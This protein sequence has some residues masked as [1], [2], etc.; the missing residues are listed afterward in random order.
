V[1]G[2]LPLSFVADTFWT[3][4]TGHRLDQPELRDNYIAVRLKIE[5]NSLSKAM[6]K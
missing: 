1:D 2:V 5:M 4:D 3:L 6:H